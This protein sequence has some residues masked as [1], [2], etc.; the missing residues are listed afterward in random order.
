MHIFSNFHYSPK[1]G[2]LRESVHLKKE[3]SYDLY[4]LGTGKSVHLE[5]KYIV[6]A[7]RECAFREN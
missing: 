1:G 7:F 3:I 5:R 6:R 4:I 2:A